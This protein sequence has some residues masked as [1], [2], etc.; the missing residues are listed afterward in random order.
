MKKV[1]NEWKEKQWIDWLI[2]VVLK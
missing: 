1:R 2:P